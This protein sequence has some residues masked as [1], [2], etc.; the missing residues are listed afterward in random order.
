M[1][2]VVSGATR[3][4]RGVTSSRCDP[5]RRPGGSGAGRPRGSERRLSFCDPPFPHLESCRGIWRRPREV[6]G[7]PGGSGLMQKS[8]E[9]SKEDPGSPQACLQPVP[10]TPE[11]CGAVTILCPEDGR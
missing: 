5:R 6:W 1:R 3:R 7:H 9:M 10:V 8:L 11:P 4:R 2:G